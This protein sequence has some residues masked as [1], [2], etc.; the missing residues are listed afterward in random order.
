MI[1]PTPPH[2]LVHQGLENSSIPERQDEG[3]PKDLEGPAYMGEI[4]IN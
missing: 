1:W 4:I 3:P 2:G